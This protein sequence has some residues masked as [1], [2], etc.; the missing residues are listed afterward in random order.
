M[1]YLLG[2]DAV[3]TEERYDWRDAAGIAPGLLEGEDAQ[4]EHEEYEAAMRRI[5]NG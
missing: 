4:G 3:E 1:V 2:G 5:Q